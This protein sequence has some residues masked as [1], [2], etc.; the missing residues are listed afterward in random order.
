[1]NSP[2]SPYQST[3]D[4]AALFS[5]AAI[6]PYLISVPPSHGDLE[7]LPSGRVLIY[8]GPDGSDID[9]LWA[10]LNDQDRSG[11]IYKT[12][13]QQLGYNDGQGKPGKEN[14]SEVEGY[15]L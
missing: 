7:L 9:E 1:M 5:P 4:W 6:L 13:C 8:T 3:P 12:V 11:N 2:L 10:T 15:D 14:G